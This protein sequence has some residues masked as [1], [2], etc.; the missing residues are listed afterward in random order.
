MRNLIPSFIAKKYSQNQYS[1]S[2]SAITMF[3]DISGF[4]P[5]TERLMR[6]GKEGAEVLSSIINNIFEPVI[7]A[8]YSTAGFVSTF[9]GDAFTA[10]FPETE[11]SLQVVACAVEINKIFQE[12]GRQKTK[13]GEFELFVKLGLSAGIVDFGIIGSDEHRTFFFRGEAIDGCAHSEHHCEKMEIVLDQ[14]ILKLVPQNQIEISLIDEQYYKLLDILTPPT[15]LY[16]RGEFLSPRFDKER[17]RESSLLSQEILKKFMP[18]QIL[19]LNQQ[20]EFR[21]IVSVFISFKEPE[22]YQKLNESVTE[23][24]N[25]CNNQGGYFNKIDFGDKGGVIL[26]LFGAPV[27]FEN[28]VIRALNFISHIKSTLHENIRAGIT[29]GIAYSGFVG[30]M[31]RCEYTALGDIVN[32]SARFMMKAE[33]GEIWISEMICKKVAKVYQI[34]DLGKMNF[35]GKAEPI[36][37]FRLHT[38]IENQE[39]AFFSGEMVGRQ[40]ELNLIL[41]NAKPLS[42]GKFANISIVYGEAGMGKSRLVYEFIKN[43]NAEILFMQTDSILKMSMNPFEYFLNNYFDQAKAKNN[44]DKKSNFEAVYELLL[45]NLENTSDERKLPIIKEIERTK[46]IFAAQ[47]DVFYENSLYEQL[48]PKG[49]YENTLFAYKE[50]FKALSLLK[51]IIIQIEDIQWLDED[52]QKVFQTLCRLIDDFPI[53]IVAT[54][55]F[56]DDGTKPNLR[57][58]KE[59]IQQEIIL[60]KLEESAANAFIELQLNGKADESVLKLINSKAEYNPFY[61]EQIIHY[62]KENNLLLFE[63]DKFTISSQNLEIPGS[64]SAI[65]VARIDRLENELKNIVQLASV[66]GREVELK[67]FLAMLELYKSVLEKNQ[68]APL[69]EKIENEQLWNSFA[70]IKYIF[71]HALLHE[72]VYE[73]QLKARLRELHNLAAQSVEQIYADDAEKYYEIA[74]HYDKAEKVIEAIRYYEKAGDWFKENYENLKAIDCYDRLLG[75]LDEEKYAGKLIDVLHSKG[76]V[77]VLIGEWNNAE[78]LFQRALD[79]S[80][81]FNDKIRIIDSI[82]KLASLKN[83][84]GDKKNAIEFLEQSLTLAEELG[85][86][87]R[88]SKSLYGLGNIY[89]TQSDNPKA[90]VFFQEA[91]LVTEKIKDKKTESDINGGMGLICEA[92]GDYINAVEYFQK[93]LEIAEELENKQS[94]SKFIGNLGGIYY[95]QANYSK[96]M[97]FFQKGIEVAKELGDKQLI[98]TITG[99]MGGVYWVK[100]DYVKSMESFKMKL[101]I[102][103]ELGDKNNMSLANGNIGALYI[104][105]GNCSK[106]IEHMQNSYKIAEQIGDKTLMCNAVGNMGNVYFTQ[107]D[108]IRALKCY[109]EALQIAEAIEDKP[110]MSAMTGNVATIYKDQGDYVKAIEY[111]KKGIQLGEELGDKKGLSI[112]VGNMGDIYYNQG[113]YEKAIECYDRAIEVSRELQINYNLCFFLVCKAFVLFLIKDYKKAHALNSEAIVLAKEVNKKDTIFNS[114][115]LSHKLLALENPNQAVSNLTQMLES[116]T[117]EPNLAGIHYEIYKI[118]QSTEHQQ[119]ALDTYQQLY[120]KSPNIEYK[121]RVDELSE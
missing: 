8:V 79:M 22:N 31:Q 27:S 46:S 25:Q 90:M 103:E 42:D 117:E 2:F 43:Q 33:W 82:I 102:S 94:I 3:L 96:A 12:I 67:L 53:M 107:A 114:T 56:N 37:V 65:I 32:Q 34:D 17:A 76:D 16:Q 84:R 63:S 20:G 1:G 112:K 80:N 47:I 108:F 36:A 88:I 85:D 24:I 111:Y 74:Y 54:S 101:Q 68:I 75:Y 4:T 99:N 91:L 120:A 26:I 71:K 92:K 44:D 13:F 105:R 40:T 45:V 98:A 30:S 19:T 109:H 64:V 93:A 39:D 57:V 121:N 89:R 52:S 5:M 61:I 58:D 60:D 14:R 95:K 66:L 86:N 72:A 38:K 118:N 51:P 49:R 83:E 10:I 73:M 21:E 62:L 6:E 41:E 9:A 23:I 48:D 15:P 87:L 59:I 69:L 11:N 70:E 77:F 78:G 104:T 115:I 7:N 113:N 119:K 18:E 106:A 29:S 81:V 110:R 35:K 28:N 97:D 50:L 100:A 116:E 55:R